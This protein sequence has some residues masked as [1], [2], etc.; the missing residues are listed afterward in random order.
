MRGRIGK[1]IDDLQLLDDGT[2]PSWSVRSTA[3]P[4]WW[5]SKTASP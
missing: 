3:S 5:L 4:V 2:S 1:W